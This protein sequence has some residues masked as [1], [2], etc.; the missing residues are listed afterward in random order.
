[1]VE[2]IPKSKPQNSS[3]YPAEQ[4]LCYEHSNYVPSNRTINV[5]CVKPLKGN[6]VRIQLARKKTQLVLCDVR[7]NGGKY[8]TCHFTTIIHNVSLKKKIGLF[9]Y[10]L[11]LCNKQDIIIIKLVCRYTLDNL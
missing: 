11:W 6:Q 9:N 1:M 4:Q 7:I 5:S 3:Y 8:R 10:F 2:N